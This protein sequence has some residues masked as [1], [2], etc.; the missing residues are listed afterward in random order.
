MINVDKK[1]CVYAHTTPSGK[2]YIGITSKEP[3][4]RWKNGRGYA[5]NRHFTNAIIKY[6]WENISHKILEFNLSKDEAVEKEIYYIRHYKA[7]S[8]NYGYNLT[9]GGGGIE[10]F[11]FS[12]ES[13]KNLSLKMSG[14]GNPFYGKK[15]SEQTKKRLC[16]VNRGKYIGGKSKRARK[17][18]QIDMNTGVVLNIFDAETTAAK[19]VG[20]KRNHI[21]CVCNGRRKSSGGFYW[22]YCEDIGFDKKVGDKVVVCKYFDGN[23]KPIHQ[24]HLG[25]G[26]IVNSFESALA[27]QR[28]TGIQ[29]SSINK[30]CLGQRKTAG[31]YFWKYQDID[32]KE[33]V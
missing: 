15:H 10:S 4:C 27:A 5:N 22:K 7:M 2:V 28:A 13:R 17:V 32:L 24:I 25:T 18:A 21:S 8:P 33:V 1:Y 19:S 26:L 3:A 29:N 23:K 16:E 9:S 11:R 12:E 6:G 14:E 31:G 20:I 30:V